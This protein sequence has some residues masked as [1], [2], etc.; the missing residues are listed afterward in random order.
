MV[1][2]VRY[3]LPCLL[4]CSQAFALELEDFPG[5]EL[6]QEKAESEF[7]IHRLLTGPVERVNTEQVPESFEFVHG[8]MKSKIIALPDVRRT[9]IVSDFY[10]QQLLDQGQL[11]FECSG[12]GCGSSSYWANKVF[13]ASLLYGPEQYQEYI[14]ARTDAKEYVIVYV[15]QRATGKR[16]AYISVITDA[17][18]QVKVEVSSVISALQVQ[19][20]YVFEYTEAATIVDSLAG[21]INQ[22]SQQKFL[23]VVH[24]RL[25]PNESVEAGRQ[26]TEK[27]AV[28]LRDQIKSA[29]G[30]VSRVISV[31][32]G[33]IAPIDLKRR[34]RG[35]L[36][37]L[38]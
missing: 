3:F 25:Q 17:T 34:H 24:D 11:L 7:A 4:F 23:L 28:K 32:A 10:R 33:P 26:R 8:R 2:I 35:E 36:V 5:A 31:G 15:A 37:L 20:K 21:A 9:S 22:N 1:S 12:R 13:S 19:G 30:D 6:E 27:E 14:L 38:L 29:G 16:Y 18:E